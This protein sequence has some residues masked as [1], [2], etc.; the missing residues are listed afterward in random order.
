[1]RA[2]ITFLKALHL[3][4][5]E[6]LVEIHNSL[7]LWASISS[8]SLRQQCKEIWWMLME[9]TWLRVHKSWNLIIH[10][11][12]LSTKAITI[13]INLSISSSSYTSSSNKLCFTNIIS[14]KFS[15]NSCSKSKKILLQIE[16]NIIENKAKAHLALQIKV[17]KLPWKMQRARKWWR[18]LMVAKWCSIQST[19]TMKSWD[20]LNNNSSSFIRSPVARV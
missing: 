2:T 7:I 18:W 12:W 6:W 13:I 16:L 19:V 11:R 17:E 4:W 10:L 3:A 20:I 8:S 1:M 9:E 15:N 5:W 14:F